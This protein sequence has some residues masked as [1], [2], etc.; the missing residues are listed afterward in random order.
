M[1]LEDF[2]EWLEAYEFDYEWE[3]LNMTR[4]TIPMSGGCYC[5]SG[6]VGSAIIGGFKF[7]WKTTK[8]KDGD[9]VFANFIKDSD[10]KG[11]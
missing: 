2:L 8:T 3:V 6:F 11:K 7:N 5:K 4:Y 1:T 10:F 9:C